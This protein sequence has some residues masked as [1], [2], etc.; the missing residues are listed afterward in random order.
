MFPDASAAALPVLV[1]SV[2]AS[3]VLVCCVSSCACCGCWGLLAAA[4]FTAQLLR[5]WSGIAESMHAV[6]AVVGDLERPACK[7]KSWVWESHEGSLRMS[8]WVVQLLDGSV[9]ALSAAAT[10]EFVGSSKNM[11]MSKA[12]AQ[13]GPYM[14]RCGGERVGA[15]N[16]PQ[17]AHAGCA[18]RWHSRHVS[19]CYRSWTG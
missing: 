15:T 19:A 8:A 10:Q 18:T 16:A 12:I 9:A 2:L 3:A 6:P 4:E 13:Y 14:T 1:S 11:P 5:D 17:P 7:R